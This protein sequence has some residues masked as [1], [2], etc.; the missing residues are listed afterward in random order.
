MNNVAINNFCS[1]FH[2]LVPFHFQ[3]Q[4]GSISFINRGQPVKIFIFYL[5]IIRFVAGALPSWCRWRIHCRQKII[6]FGNSRKEM[7]SIQHQFD[8]RQRRHRFSF[9]SSFR[10]KSIKI[11]CTYI[12]KQIARR[13]HI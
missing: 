8:Y 7:R 9:E 4:H 3:A 2:F 10:Q 12:H 1:L 13:L 6:R 5:I 11:H